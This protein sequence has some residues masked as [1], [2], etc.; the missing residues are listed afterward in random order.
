MASFIT[1]LETWS[2]LT[3]RY[4]Q[5]TRGFRWAVDRP[6][7]ETERSW[8]VIEAVKQIGIKPNCP[9]CIDRKEGCALMVFHSMFALRNFRILQRRPRMKTH[10]DS[11]APISCLHCLLQIFG[12]FA[13]VFNNS[14]AAASPCASRTRNNSSA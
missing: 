9:P 10:P 2:I 12:Y 4:P 1:H 3:N 11:G 5:R 14:I 8:A 6:N 13:L 7:V